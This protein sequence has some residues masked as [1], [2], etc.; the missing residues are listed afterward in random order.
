[1]MVTVAKSLDVPIKLV[2]PRPAAPDA[3]PGA[4]SHAM[5]G[6]G[7]VVLPGIMIGL[8]LRFD[9]YF[10]YL[11]K[12][13]KAAPSSS[14]TEAASSDPENGGEKEL[15]QKAKYVPLTNHTAESFW[16]HSLS[17]R[18]LV[19]GLSTSFPKPYFTA[20]IIGYVVGMLATLG[21]MQ[22]FNHA[23]PALL[24][25]V[26]SVLISLWGTALVRSEIKEMWDF[27]EAVEE[28]AAAGENKK[29]GQKSF[30]SAEKQE[31]QAKRLEKA[32][33]RLVK[34]DEGGEADEHGQHD[35]MKDDDEKPAEE[36]IKRKGANPD[37]S[38]EL[39][40][41]SISAPF[42]LSTLKDTKLASTAETAANT[43]ETQASRL[44]SSSGD[45]IANSLDNNP[46]SRP[47]RRCSK[48]GEPAEK[49]QRTA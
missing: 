29:K 27:S 46:R 8:A 10:F 35:K 13:T 41:F 39:V 33:G 5:L 22:V 31:R 42:A 23:Q 34:R 11:R 21:V 1:M 9:L 45:E 26:P 28:E 16:T 4:S 6:L 15:A 12:Q 17:G 47:S 18:P 40:S 7:D 19:P 3:P 44:E 36:I 49:Q 32:V 24:Y 38:R 2:F 30:F 37:R 43:A 20:S 25:L 48:K 14:S